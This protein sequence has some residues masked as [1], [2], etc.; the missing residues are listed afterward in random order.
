MFFSVEGKSLDFGALKAHRATAKGNRYEGTS[1]PKK[2]E[3][4]GKIAF[5]ERR[6]QLSEGEIMIGR[7]EIV[8]LSVVLLMVPH[9]L[10]PGLPSFC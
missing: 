1:A 9:C 5:L 2:I 8:V 6:L 4:C 3:L 7:G 10:P